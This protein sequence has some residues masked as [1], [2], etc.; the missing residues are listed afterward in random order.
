MQGIDQEL[1]RCLGQPRGQIVPARLF[2]LTDGHSSG[3][4]EAMVW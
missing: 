2:H 1:L 3:Q 4:I